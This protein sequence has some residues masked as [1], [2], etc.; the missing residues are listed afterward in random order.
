M[1]CLVLDAMGVIFSS[2]DD[3]AELLIP[4]IAEKSG[5]CDEDLIQSAYLQASLGQISP[6]DFWHQVG[7]ASDLED[8]YLSRHTLN[9]GITELM[10]L[11]KRNGIAV[12][13]L[14]NDVGRWSDKL[15]SNHCLEILLNGSI[16]SGDV[17]VRK[18]DNEIYE[19]LIH[20]SGCR[21]D[22]ILFVDDREKNVIASRQLGMETIM[23]KTEIGFTDVKNWVEK[24]AQ[25]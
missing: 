12:W 9:P 2:A 25:R 3:V 10:S 7:V 11:A 21:I 13:C 23:F 22:E 1:S 24:R 19:I 6:D 14:S 17:G 5:T 8:E 20:S 16:I 4:F 18:P 15:R